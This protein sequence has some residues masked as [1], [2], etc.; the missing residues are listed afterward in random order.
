MDEKEKWQKYESEKQKILMEV[1]S[2]EEYNKKIN[3]LVERLGL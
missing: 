3:E 2:S 1:K